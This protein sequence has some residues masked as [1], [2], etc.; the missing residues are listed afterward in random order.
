MNAPLQAIR[1]QY[2]LGPAVLSVP[3]PLRGL[4][5]EFALIPNVGLE[6]TRVLPHRIL[7]PVLLPY[8]W[9]WKRV[10]VTLRGLVSGQFSDR[11][12]VGESSRLARSEALAQEPDRL[13]IANYGGNSLAMSRRPPP[14]FSMPGAMTEAFFKR[15]MTC[16]GVRS[17]FWDKR[18]AATAATIGAEKL[19]P[20]PLN[21]S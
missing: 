17:G 12:S 21:L 1:P 18:V 10:A 9:S 19:V 11:R 6:P 15:A 7:S 8:T 16:A 14:I 3:R 2:A 13:V 5:D 20:G 4:G